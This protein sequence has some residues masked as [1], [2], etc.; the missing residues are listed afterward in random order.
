MLQGITLV[1]TIRWIFLLG[2]TTASTFAA[3]LPPRY[4]AVL[5]HEDDTA[6]IAMS[7]AELAAFKTPHDAHAHA[8]CTTL[9]RRVR[10]DFFNQVEPIATMRQFVERAIECRHGQPKNAHDHAQV[11]WLQARLLALLTFSGEHKRTLAMFADVQSQLNANRARIAPADYAIAAAALGDAAFA[12]NNIEA[13]YSWIEASVDATQNGDA[14]TRMIHA[15]QLKYA[16]YIRG[17]LS[18]FAEAQLAGTQAVAVAGQIF[19]IPSLA[20]T[21]A[22]FTLGEVQ[23]FANDFGQARATLTQSIAEARHLGI[24]GQGALASSLGFWGNLQRRIGNYD[25]GRAA[26][27]ESIAIARNRADPHKNQLDPKLSNLAALEIESGHCDA[28]IAPLREALE[29]VSRHYGPDN[30]GLVHKL[31]NLGLCEMESGQVQRARVDMNRMLAIAIKSYGEN[32][33]QLALVYSQL[34][35]VDL[36]EHDYA[37]AT[38]RLQH[39]LSLLPADPD[40]LGADRIVIERDLASSLHLQQRDKESFEHAV[41]AE[42][43]RQHLL[44]RFANALDEGEGLDLRQTLSGGMDQVLA[45]AAARP[46]PDLTRRAWQLQIGSR[47]LITRLVAARLKAARNS[48][49]PAI[50]ALWQQ[51]QAAN[52]AY[53]R[54]LRDGELGK[55][56]IKT[57]QDRREALDQAE[58]A[59]AAHIPGLPESVPDFTTLLAALPVDSAL[60]GFALGSSDPWTIKQAKRPGGPQHYYAF[61]LASSNKPVLVDLGDALAIDA[62]VHDWTAELRDPT[63]DLAQVTILGTDVRRRIW[64]PLNLPSNLQQVFIVP[65]GQ[66]HRV[67]WLAV[68]LSKHLLVESGLVPQLLDSERDLAAAQVAAAP[69]DR[70]LLVGAVPVAASIDACKHADNAALPGASRELNSLRA[71]WVA[72]QSGHHV[73][74][75]AG[76][77]ATKSAVLAAM[78]QS[79]II[80]FAT[81]ALSEDTDCALQQVATRG[82]RIAPATKAKPA[83][84]LSGLL[85]AADPATAS[86]RDDG[87]LTAQEIAT[88]NLDAAASVT[89]AACDTGLGAIKPDEGVFGLARAFHLAGARS[90]VMS[91][92]S[93]DDDATAQLM[94]R[95]YHANW[96]EHAAPADALARAARETLA[97][98][99]AAGQSIHP[100]YWAGFVATDSRH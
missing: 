72:R 96:I 30:I 10:I 65:E 2:F 43:S 85:L 12:G 17:R 3:T 52:S 97:A 16:C 49:D 41:A 53:S 73:T 9:E 58:H 24:R 15:R 19:G 28:A 93:V 50:A 13:A 27:T 76:S 62:A 83:V 86:T 5:A 33:P 34:A 74:Y 32:N 71:L 88:L 31:G 6:A 44:R 70:A 57:L 99:R 95:M 4:V 8:Y 94:Q 1:A 61:R 98:R 42:T 75:L 66:L 37:G 18:R 25:S 59:L 40:V 79:N 91:L 89:L 46:D 14:F 69:A 87:L 84:A 26:L 36:A 55:A 68:P 90:V 63:R 11:A 7:D 47:L 67:A 82:I 22:L 81:H 64:D 39:A 29:I 77:D 48:P 56:D 21:D 54:A 78:P 38:G 20:H 60:I 100:Y 35:Q 92:W 23:Y 45:L 51:W 80:H